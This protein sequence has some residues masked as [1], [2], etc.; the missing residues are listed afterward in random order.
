[1]A[2]LAL[3][4]LLALPDVPELGRSAASMTL[5][6]GADDLEMLLTEIELQKQEIDELRLA[7]A[8]ARLEASNATRERDELRQ[9]IEDNRQYGQDFQQYRAVRE[10]AEAEAR[11]KAVEAAREQREIEKADRRERMRLARERRERQQAEARRLASYRERG[12]APLGL[13][14]YISQMAYSYPSVDA[15][16]TRIAYNPGFG[17]YLRLYPATRIDFSSMTISGSVVSA[18]DEVR[19]IGVAIAFFDEDGNQVGHETVQI[20][21]ARPDVPYPFT[22]TISMALDRPFSSSTQYVLYADEID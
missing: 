19:N 18:A 11:R 21:N 22:S 3:L 15:T 8:A 2:A 13:D 12:F 17:N 9:F 14:V 7:L 5:A 20:N 1:M 4:T 16:A 6:A 10:A